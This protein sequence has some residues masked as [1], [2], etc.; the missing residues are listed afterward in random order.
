AAWTTLALG[1]QGLDDARVEV[2]LP[3][4]SKQALPAAVLALVSVAAGAGLWLS[5]SRTRPKRGKGG[6]AYR[7]TRRLGAGG[8]GEVW[9]GLSL[10]T[11]GFQRR[12]AIKRIFPSHAE[13]EHALRMF[14]DEARI[15]SSLHHANIV[16]VLDFG[17]SEG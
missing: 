10:G 15:A 14:M 9:E 1:V 4:L 3:P 13:S 16:A 12:V 8:M 7:L 11:G 6:R 2:Q 5:S 17:V